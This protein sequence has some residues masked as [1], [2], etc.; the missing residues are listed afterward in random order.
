MKKSKIKEIILAVTYRCNARCQMCGIWKKADPESLSLEMVKKL[1]GNLK[2]INLTGGEPFLNPEIVEIV[3]LLSQKSPRASLI[4]SSNGFATEI[5]LKKMEEIIGINP[6]VGVA[7]SIDGIGEKH[8]VIRGIPGGFEKV[9]RT[10]EGLKKT[11][12]KK[13]RLS[14][15]LGDYNIS[16]LKPVYALSQKLGIELSLTLVHSSEEYFNTKNPIIQKQ[17]MAKVLDWL[18]GEELGS[19][20]LKKWLRAYYAY[21]MKQFVLTGKRILPDYSGQEGVFIDPLG[22]IFPSDISMEKMGN[23]EKFNFQENTALPPSKNPP[24]WMICTARTAIRKHWF[25]TGL[26]IFKNKFIKR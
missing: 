16:Q 3:R 24:S 8:D 25:K 12:V 21:G 10:I 9:L 14:F 17:A 7:F 6:K 22:N 11:G 1:P 19:W 2:D 20:N 23:V 13:L 18:I 4:I 5:I 15:T 26:W